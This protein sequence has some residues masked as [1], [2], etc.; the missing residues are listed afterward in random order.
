MK[1]NQTITEK[2]GRGMNQ[3][4]YILLIFTIFV[5][6][7]AFSQRS[8]SDK[9]LSPKEIWN[10]AEFSLQEGKF[11][12]A[13][14]LYRKLLNQNPQ[15]PLLNF[16]VGYAY[17]NTDYGLEQ[18]ITYLK[19]AIEFQTEKPEEKAPI[20]A[21]YYLGKAYHNNYQFDEAILVLN[22]LLERSEKN[23][24][25]YISSR[26]NALLKNAENGQM[27]TQTSANI[28][29]NNFVEI[30]SKYADRNPLIDLQSG[31]IIFTSRRENPIM[32]KKLDD[33]QFDENIYLS[34]IKEEG[35][36]LPYGLSNSINSRDHELTCWLSENGNQLLFKLMD[37]KG[38]N[39]YLVKKK[40]DG[41]WSAP[42]KLD[43]VIND[44][45][46]TTF[47]SFSPDGRYLY[48]TS[49]RN[50]GYGGSD[51]YEAEYLGNNKWGPVSNLGPQINTQFNEESPNMHSN[52]ILYFSSEGHTSMG[53][54]D[55]FSS[56]KNDQGNWLEP[57]NLGIPVNSVY[58][59]LFY[60]PLPD[61]Q[62]AYL[63]SDRSGTKGK[64]DIFKVEYADSLMNTN[65]I[66]AGNIKCP[67]GIDPH[68]NIGIKL[69]NQHSNSQEIQLKPSISGYYNF[70]LPADSD[71][72]IEFGYQDTVFYKA[73]LKIS[74]SY[75][76]VLF[77][78]LI[79]IKDLSIDPQNLKNDTLIRDIYASV[80][81]N[82]QR[83]KEA[84][85][86]SYNKLNSK[87]H[88]DSTYSTV[89]YTDEN[90][91]ADSTYSIRI[92]ISKSPVS[93]SKFSDLSNVK[94]IR[95]KSGNYIYYFGEYNYEWEALVKLRLIQDSYPDA[96]LFISQKQLTELE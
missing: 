76:T 43:K 66:I 11:E 96:S 74:K 1:C 46:A 33:S 71:Y 44:G 15:N 89:S 47:G 56:Y 91:S 93:L 3:L 57:V 29:I 64:I 26:T 36:N 75:S 82:N 90:L 13:L 49:D 25:D 32:R 35:Y 61:G 62:T 87:N 9:E 38:E 27:L 18:S 73:I 2:N 48:F 20:E 58:D 40:L 78:Q 67:E 16:L 21:Y 53:G 54:F 30:N 7:F 14:L 12:K 51:I 85:L 86:L 59:D 65:G 70:S 92:A 37:K 45:S 5:S 10:Q 55:I 69:K 4:N 83:I 84:Y 28:K 68:R 23:L 17:L 22:E 31:T 63:S 60:N 81:K 80:S 41:H 94:E 6:S 79:H 88:A 8:S 24:I 34:E 95:D 42:E 52:G 50:G 72:I 39:L 19:N 77:D